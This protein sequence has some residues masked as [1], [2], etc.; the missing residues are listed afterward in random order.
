MILFA[1]DQWNTEHIAE[2]GILPDEAE[3][4]VRHAR[5]PFPR[6]IGDDKYV[7]WGQTPGGRYIR[8]IFVYRSDDEVEYESIELED[9][10]ELSE[11][12]PTVVYVI[13]AMELTDRMK[14]QFRRM[15]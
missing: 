3:Y 1:W 2:H 10:L 15:K 14:R 9:V 7:V 4:V 12:H 5:A 11:S 6:E 13:H 8:V